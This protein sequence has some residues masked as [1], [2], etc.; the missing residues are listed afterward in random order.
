MSKE[1]VKQLTGVMASI[2]SQSVTY[3]KEEAKKIS[4]LGEK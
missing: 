2:F 4:G 1:K 3:R